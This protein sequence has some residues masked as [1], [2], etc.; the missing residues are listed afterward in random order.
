MK[1]SI[2]NKS[3]TTPFNLIKK[4]KSQRLI[5]NNEYEAEK[6]LSKINYFRFK[7]Y[8]RPFLDTT[9]KK[10]NSNS[11][12]NDAYDLYCFDEELQNIL[13]SIISQIE[14][15]L[16]TK[17]DQYVTPFVNDTL[18]EFREMPPFWIISEFSTFG[19]ILT[20]LESMNK[21]AFVLPQ[22]NNLLDKLSQEF[23]AKNLKELNSW[24]RL[25]RDV[26]NRVAHHS[27]VWNCN[28]REPSGIRQKISNSFNP[29]QANKIYL[30]L[31]F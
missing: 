2:Y 17:I 29:I 18:D 21:K 6:I 28:Y 8:L 27:R 7:I 31:L 22:N 9:T 16:R 24:L 13:H 14:I 25:I 20:I 15:N 4:L 26:R 1:Y 11:T 19:N 10:F 30:F 5:I 12:F 23:G 3:Y